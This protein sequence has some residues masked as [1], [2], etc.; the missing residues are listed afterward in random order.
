MLYSHFFRCRYLDIPGC[1]GHLFAN[2]LKLQLEPIEDEIGLSFCLIR[3]PLDRVAS[4]YSNKSEEF[5]EEISFFDWITSGSLD[6]LE[7]QHPIVSAHPD[8]KI[9]RFEDMHGKKDD[10]WYEICCELNLDY[11]PFKKPIKW[12][13]RNYYNVHYDSTHANIVSEIFK[14]DMENL[15]YKME[16][17]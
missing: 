4:L 11:K 16:L 17:I 1:G 3:D 15:N 5:K 2:K 9:G 6:E 12:G 8:F 10:F 7:L 13:V 14:E